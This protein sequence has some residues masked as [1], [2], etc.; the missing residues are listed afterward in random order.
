MFVLNLQKMIS[1]FVFLVLLID[2]T[3][4]HNNCNDGCLTKTYCLSADGSDVCSNNNL[5][6]VKFSVNELLQYKDYLNITLIGSQIEPADTRTISLQFY[7]NT[8]VVT[9]SCTKSSLG[10]TS[11]SIVQNGNTYTIG[12]SYYFENSLL[13]SW[14]MSK[15]DL[16]WPTYNGRKIDLITDSSYK[17]VL[18][19]DSL[20]H[21][22]AR[23]TSQLPIY[24]MQFLKCCNQIHGTQDYQLIVKQADYSTT[25]YLYEVDSTAVNNVAVSLSSSDNRSLTINCNLGYNS[26]TGTLRT[27]S[28]TESISGQLYSKY[29]DNYRCAWSQPFTIKSSYKP[30]ETKNRVFDLKI[31]ADNIVVYTESDVSLKGLASSVTANSILTMITVL[32]T[33]LIR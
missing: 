22:I 25:F 8:P 24:Q 31:V 33:F 3:Q 10:S 2:I 5:V 32:F 15:D 4:S 28:N 18:N 30:F 16:S 7:T 21:L 14:I 19:S 29:V 1:F 13:C 11:A 20:N 12:S 17:L 9:Y 6:Q 27:D 23:D 26:I